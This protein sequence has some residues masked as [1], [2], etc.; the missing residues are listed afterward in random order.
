MLQGDDARAVFKFP[1]L[2]A[3]TKATV[4][5]LVQRQVC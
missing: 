4:F 2:I 5:P 3:P 1:P